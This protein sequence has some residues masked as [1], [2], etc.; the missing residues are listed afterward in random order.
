MTPVDKNGI[1]VLE[2]HK[3]P[4]TMTKILNISDAASLAMHS[5]VVLASNR[6]R[7]IST[8]EIA[9]VLKASENHLSKVMQRLVKGRLIESK[10]GP[11]GGFIISRPLEEITVRDIYESIEGKFDLNTCLFAHPV[12]GGEGCILGDLLEMIHDKIQDYFTKTTLHDFK[13]GFFPEKI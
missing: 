8:K 1:V 12:C 9:K 10:R 7:N 5:M 3:Y 11:E 6:E 2:Y 13:K 4:G